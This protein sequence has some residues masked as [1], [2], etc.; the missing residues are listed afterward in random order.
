MCPGGRHSYYRE[1]SIGI[2]VREGNLAEQILLILESLLLGPSPGRRRAKLAGPVPGRVP[3]PRPGEPPAAAVRAG[4]GRPRGS[5]PPRRA[6]RRPPRPHSRAARRPHGAASLRVV[7]EVGRF[8]PSRPPG[9][10]GG[11]PRF[12]RSPRPARRRP[13]PARC[14]R[15]PRPQPHTPTTVAVG[16]HPH[17]GGRVVRGGPVAEWRRGDGNRL[18]IS[19]RPAAQRGERGR[20][21]SVL[22]PP[23]RAGGWPCLA[24][25]FF[26]RSAAPLRH[27]GT[28]GRA[29][30]WSACCPPPVRWSPRLDSSPCSRWVRTLPAARP[31]PPAL[32]DTPLPPGPSIALL[33]GV[34][35]ARLGETKEAPAFQ[36][37]EAGGQGESRR[38]P[39]DLGSPFR[40]G[41]PSS[42]QA[43]PGEWPPGPCVRTPAGEGE[44]VCER[45]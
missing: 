31:E 43:F 10:R 14:A 29:G 15:R 9:S 1:F 38:L 45:A 6:W 42:A 2:R 16:G 37:L 36:G 11:A 41:G 12:P 26:P 22:P 27:S 28:A 32:G 19:A 17:R 3:S 35:C 21:R 40:R 18:P 30:G 23:A 5:A 20:E 33:P 39:R 7:A 44:A 8:L 4:A 13:R 34:F 24:G 25:A